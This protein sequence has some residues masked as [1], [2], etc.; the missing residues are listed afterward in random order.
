[1]QKKTKTCSGAH[2]PLLGRRLVIVPRAGASVYLVYFGG[3]TEELSGYSFSVAGTRHVVPLFS[4]QST[5]TT[6]SAVAR[7]LSENEQTTQQPNRL[8]SRNSSQLPE[9]SSLLS[10]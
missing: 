4:T 8:W 6:D 9:K 5:S 3:R 1:L 10:D 2:A 7:L